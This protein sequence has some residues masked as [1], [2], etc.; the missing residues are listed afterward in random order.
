[1]LPS[2]RRKLMMQS[3]D[4]LMLLSESTSLSQQVFITRKTALT[5]NGG[6]TKEVQF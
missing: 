4:V 1:L 2:T 5:I 3:I 6:K